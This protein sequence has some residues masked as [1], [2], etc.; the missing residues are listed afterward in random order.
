MSTHIRTSAS[1]SDPR[2]EPGAVIPHAGICAGGAGRPVFL[3][4]QNPL[5]RRWKHYNPLIFLGQIS[6]FRAFYD[7]IKIDTSLT[8]VYTYL[9]L[10]N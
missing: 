1:A 4:R 2:Q 7:S 6:R 10:Q 8:V 9:L 3:P 5:I